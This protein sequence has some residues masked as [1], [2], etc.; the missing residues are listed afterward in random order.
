MG[1]AV[2][3]VGNYLSHSPLWPFVNYRLVAKIARINKQVWTTKRIKLLKLKSSFS[4]FKLF[5]FICRFTD[6]SAVS[7]NLDKMWLSAVWNKRHILWRRKKRKFGLPSREDIFGNWENYYQ[8]GISITR[9]KTTDVIGAEGY[10]N[11]HCQPKTF[12]PLY[13][14]WWKYTQFLFA[15]K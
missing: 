8:N 3:S 14:R 5:H 4:L 6:F 11:R 12:T 7:D 13:L 10:A 1:S 15:K 2:C 9:M